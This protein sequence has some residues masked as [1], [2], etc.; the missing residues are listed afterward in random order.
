[1]L[2]GRDAAHVARRR[3]F[4]LS[5]LATNEDL[6]SCGTRATYCAAC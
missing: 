6:R 2:A 5:K 1:M 3:Y 4:I